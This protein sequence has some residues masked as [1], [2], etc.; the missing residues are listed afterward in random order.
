MLG[1]NLTQGVYLQDGDY[2]DTIMLTLEEY[3]HKRKT[4]D[5]INE[6]DK[7]KRLENIQICSNYIFEYFH[8]YMDSF[9]EDQ[10]TVLHTRRVEKY[11]D[12]LGNYTPE[13]REWLVELYAEYGK[14]VNVNIRNMIEDDLFLLYDSDA[15]YRAL[16]YRIYAKA[17]KKLPFLSGQSENLFNLLKDIHTD[18]SVMT[19]FQEEYILPGDVNDWVRKTYYKYGV[20]LYAFA[21]SYINWFLQSPEVWPKNRKSRF[22]SRNIYTPDDFMYWHYDCRPDDNRFNINELYRRIPKKPFIK[23][24]KKRLE[25]VLMYSWLFQIDG[26]DRQFWGEYCEE[27][28][29]MQD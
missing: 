7:D 6:K 22:E 16:S 12:R 20:N 19:P 4:E 25:A 5:G 26:E 1:N 29:K 8:H 3:I 18:D 14:Y 24:N 28:D 11:R 13:I 21:D 17:I 15:E 2:R 9:P 10:K 27:Y 23:D